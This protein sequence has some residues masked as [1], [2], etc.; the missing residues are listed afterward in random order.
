MRPAGSWLTWTNMF[1][2][3]LYSTNMFVRVQS[4]HLHPVLPP[5]AVSG[6]PSPR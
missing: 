5:A 2:T 4:W 6:R 1:A 3:N